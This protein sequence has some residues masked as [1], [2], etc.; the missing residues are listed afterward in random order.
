MGCSLTKK[1]HNKN[2]IFR[3]GYQ[4]GAYVRTTINVFIII[5]II[6]IN[7]KLPSKPIIVF[8]YFIGISDNMNQMVE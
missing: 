3:I 7:L 8:E 2:L 6:I 5:I 1:D 4:N